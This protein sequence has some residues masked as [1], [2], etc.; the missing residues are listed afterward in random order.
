[1][2]DD[3]Q[4]RHFA[5]EEEDAEAHRTAEPEGRTGDARPDQ[6]KKREDD[7]QP[8]FLRRHPIAL[9]L[10]LVLL[11]AAGIG[12]YFYWRTEI[13]PYE[14]TDDAFIDSRQ[15]GIAP[16]VS[17]YVVQVAVTDNQHVDAG[18]ILF[19]IEPKDF[20]LAIDQAKARI[21]A[22][23]ASIEAIEA[24]IAG[25]RAQIDQARAQVQESEASLRFA[26]QEATR[27]QDLQARGAGTVQRSQQSASSLQQ[28]QA[29]LTGAN[30]SVKAAEQQIGVL[31]AQRAS[32]SAD[33]AQAMTQLDQAQLNLSY[34]TVTAA[35]SGRIVRLTGA[36]GQFAQAGQSLAMFVPDD[37]WVTANF[38]ET[39][40]T[41][42]RPGQA[43]EIRIDAYPDRT[44]T[45]RLASIQPGSGTAF[46]LL[47]AENATGNYIKVVQRVPVKIA[48]DSWP[49]DIAI[50]PGMSVVPKIRVR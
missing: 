33:M 31:Q 32:A 8:G 25:Q 44:I 19:R 35:Q 20:E 48:V 42:M 39:Q 40:I 50:G 46:S 28:Q 13:L 17:G 37:V 16:K 34:A 36:R 10:G 26:R 18:A 6:V 27:Y 12:G 41:D 2:P 23:Q 15:F 9:L 29:G 14:T 45:G 3:L 7:D 5:I 21:E 38:K 47:P 24:Q 43:V 22:A 49:G 4:R 1:M 30:A 11:V